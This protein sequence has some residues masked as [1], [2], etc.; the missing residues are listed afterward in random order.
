MASSKNN[1]IAELAKSAQIENIF[2]T[3]IMRHVLKNVD[4]LNNDL[5]ELILSKEKLIPSE[6]KSNQG[7]W[8]SS[9][10]FFRWNDAPV[11]TLSGYIDKALHIATSRLAIP[12]NYRFE[13]QFYGWAAVNRKGDYNISHVHPMANWSGVYYVDV[14]DEIPGDNISGALELTHPVCAATMSF[15]PGLLPSEFVIKPETGMIILFPS[16][17]HHSVRIYMGDRPRICTPFNASMQL[18]AM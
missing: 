11:K 10:D 3:P 7:G 13:F 8:Q 12:D 9:G 14:G 2:S 6:R 18:T 15:F 16:Y 4:N 17:L 1:P 5:R